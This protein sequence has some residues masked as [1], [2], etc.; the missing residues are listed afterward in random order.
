[1]RRCWPSIC[2]W[3]ILRADCWWA[4]AAMSPPGASGACPVGGCARGSGW[5]CPW[6][7][8]PASWMGCLPSR[9]EKERQSRR[10]IRCR[11][12]PPQVVG[13]AHRHLAA[14]AGADQGD[15]RAGGGMEARLGEP[16]R[17]LQRQFHIEDPAIALIRGDAHL[18]H[19]VGLHQGRRQHLHQPI[20]MLLLQAQQTPPKPGAAGVIPQPHR[21]HRGCLDRSEQAGAGARACSKSARKALMRGTKTSTPTTRSRGDC[22]ASLSQRGGRAGW[23]NSPATSGKNEPTPEW[24]QGCSPDWQAAGLRWQGGENGQA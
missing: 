14:V 8:K 19:V 11:C 13:H 4:C 12:D 18:D 1:M 3:R 7:L 9:P 24:W 6:R 10:R 2:C 23:C 16:L 17:H 15:R 21:Q 20:G 22:W 5:P